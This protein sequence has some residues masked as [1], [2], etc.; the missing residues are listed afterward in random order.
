MYIYKITNLFNNKIY[1]GQTVRDVRYRWNHHKTCGVSAIGKAIKKHG[2]EN[3]KFEIIETVLNIEDLNKKEIECIRTFNSIAPNGYNLELGGLNHRISDITRNKMSIAKI[4]K[5]TSDKQKTTVSE[6][7]KKYN[8]SL[9]GKT[10]QDCEYIKKA[11]EGRSR[12]QYLTP[13]GVFYSSYDAA[14]ANGCS[15]PTIFNRCKKQIIGW[16]FI[17]KILKEEK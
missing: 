4:G 12:G 13:E 10:K 2:V 5:T 3:F 6:L 16:N 11:S 17:P 14:N 9:K 1:I 8:L 7:I 15:Q